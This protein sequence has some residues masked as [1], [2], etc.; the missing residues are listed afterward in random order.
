MLEKDEF[1]VTDFKTMENSK[2]FFFFF[3]VF[4]LSSLSTESPPPPVE[5]M[6][7]LNLELILK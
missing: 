1:V 5:F 3:N 6:T 4:F 2:G 7:Y